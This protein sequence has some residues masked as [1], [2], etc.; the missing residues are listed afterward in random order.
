MQPDNNTNGQYRPTFAPPVD[1][2]ESD[3]EIVVV[4]DL[5]GAQ[6]DSVDIKFEKDQL[7]ISAKRGG[8]GSG[9]LLF[10]GLREGDYRRTFV[11]PRG[12][13]SAQ[14]TADMSDGVLRVHLPKSSALKPRTIAVQ[15]RN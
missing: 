13:D 1:V 5:P 2:Y 7:Q 11:V 10:G 9:Q 15:S 4:A 6:P 8:E 12:I 3:D 14:I